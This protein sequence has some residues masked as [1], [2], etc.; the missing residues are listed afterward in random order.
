MFVVYIGSILTTILFFHALR[1]QG[2]TPFI[3]SQRNALAMANGGFCKILPKPWQ[4]AAAKLRLRHCVEQ[5]K[6]SCKE[7]SLALRALRKCN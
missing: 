1:G 7:I 3:H 2:S 4:K 5:R 6:M